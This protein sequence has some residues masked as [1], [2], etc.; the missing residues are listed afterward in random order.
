M[1]IISNPKFYIKSS[2]QISRRVGQRP[3]SHIQNLIKFT[4]HMF[5]LRKLQVVIYQCEGVSQERPIY[6]MQEL[7]EPTQGD[8]PQTYGITCLVGAGLKICI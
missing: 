5:F 8:Y 2:D 1:E 7:G 6:G 4:S 3:F